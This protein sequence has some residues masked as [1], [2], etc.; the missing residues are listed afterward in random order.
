MSAGDLFVI[1]GSLD[2]LSLPNT[3]PTSRHTFQLHL[4]E[5][6]TQ[7]HHTRFSTRVVFVDPWLCLLL[8]LFNVF[9]VTQ[10]STLGEYVVFASTNSY[11]DML[12]RSQHDSRV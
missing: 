3:S 7:V 2:H 10:P 1:H 4:I 8:M 6:P 5:G 11:N 9:F 12:I